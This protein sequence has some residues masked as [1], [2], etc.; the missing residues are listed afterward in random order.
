MSADAEVPEPERNGCWVHVTFGG[1]EALVV[2]TDQKK[3]GLSPNGHAEIIEIAVQLRRTDEAARK[4]LWLDRAKAC[5]LALMLVSLTSLASST[6]ALLLVG[7]MTA[8]I[9]KAVVVILQPVVLVLAILIGVCWLGTT[10]VGARF[11][12]RRRRRPGRFSRLSR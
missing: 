5:C 6:A 3:N 8:A 9:L 1:N 7:T 4:I 2:E 12:A 10:R 11:D